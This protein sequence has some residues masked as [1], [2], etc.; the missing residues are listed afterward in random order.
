MGSANGGAGW[1]PSLTA[2]KIHIVLDIADSMRFL[3][4]SRVVHRDLK[5]SN[6]LIDVGGR[7]KISDF[8]LSRTRDASMSHVTGVVGTV[9]WTAPEVLLAS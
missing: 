7:A 5:S 6:V 3:H 8:G 9:A 1:R 2:E 4:S